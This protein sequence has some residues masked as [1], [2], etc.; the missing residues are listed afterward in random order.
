MRVA[1][2]T[3]RGLTSHL[4]QHNLQ[5]AVGLGVCEQI[6]AVTVGVCVDHLPSG[7]FLRP[8]VVP[9]ARRVPDERH[10][11]WVEMSHQN[12]GLETVDR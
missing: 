1:D 5:T 7:D 11:K 12:V 4:P 9:I 2:T 3:W 6:L 10:S 8:L